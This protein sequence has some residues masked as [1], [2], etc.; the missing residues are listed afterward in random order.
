[1]LPLWIADALMFVAVLAMCW[2]NVELSE[3]MSLAKTL[4]CSAL[5]LA[6]LVLLALPLFFE[7]R[8]K[9]AGVREDSEKKKDEIE[10]NFRVIYE[11]LAAIR[12][13]CADFDERL[14]GDE[15]AIEKLALL[16]NKDSSFAKSIKLL[17]Q[18]L[19]EQ[20]AKLD[21]QEDSSESVLER[22][23]GNSE[24]ISAIEKAFGSISGEVEKIGL[25]EKK[26]AELSAELS[27][28]VSALD[29]LRGQTELLK[30][31]MD[32]A[33]EKSIFESVEKSVSEI[34]KNL[35]DELSKIRERIEKAEAI[36]DPSSG[37]F[38]KAI[39]QAGSGDTVKKFLSGRKDEKL[40]VANVSAD[41]G[42]SASENPAETSEPGGNFEENSE[43][44]VGNSP[45]SGNGPKPE[46]V[47]FFESAGS[48]APKSES[49]KISEGEDLSEA[50]EDGLFGDL[51]DSYERPRKA[52]KGDCV[53]IV[54]T[55]IGIGNK[56]Y[57]RGEGGG[58]STEKGTEMDYLEIGRWRWVA[59]REKSSGGVRFRVLKNDKIES[60]G[61]ET[62]EVG[63]RQTL[64]LNL[65]FPEDPEI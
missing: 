64:E 33:E 7:H 59:P 56:P 31:K 42:D 19:A 39:S 21:S 63:E 54:N 16:T 51:E 29:S 10:T 23:R 27:K 50:S 40:E 28:S 22:A 14:E 65:K 4:A 8:E 18:G 57:L 32:G 11:D 34:R 12:S 41:T 62:F 30:E 6:A 5:V 25:L 47:D 3:R 38:L 9:L 52:K 36:G 44:E 1:M 45:E 53:V 17:E 43:P 37:M 55:L 15:S 35:E 24:R 20:A 60:E 48:D 26:L 46:G 58:L 61:S 2:D 13:M 49:G